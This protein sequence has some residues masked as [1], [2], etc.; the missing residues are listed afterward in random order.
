[1][2]GYLDRS[3]F[4]PLLV[5]EPS[6]DACRR[7]WDDADAVV[8]SRMLYVETAAALAQAHRMARL[9]DAAYASCRGLLDQL[10]PQ[11]EVIEVDEE[12]IRRAAELTGLLALRGYDAVHC[13]AAEQLEDPDLVVASGDKRL[14]DAWKSLRLATFDTNAPEDAA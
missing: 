4:V 13:A 14:L 10:W 7:F 6:S 9:D 1:M 12:L 3:A 2:I 8:S 11:L 5:S